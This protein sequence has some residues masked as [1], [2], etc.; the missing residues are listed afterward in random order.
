MDPVLPGGNRGDHFLGTRLSGAPRNAHDFYV[1][2]IPVELSDVKQ[3]LPRG[4]HK[5]V[6]EIR[7]AQIFMGNHTGRPGLDCIRNK[8]MRIDFN[9]VDGDKEISGLY[10]SAVDDDALNL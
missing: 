6:R 2:G 1:K 9:S 7:L 10:L 4:F 3:R 8:L 5:D